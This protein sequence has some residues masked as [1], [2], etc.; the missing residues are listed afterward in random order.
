MDHAS[1]YDGMC[2]V[3]DSIQRAGSLD[4]KAIVA[5]LSKLDRKGYM[6]RY[7]FDQKTHTVKDGESFLAVPTA[8]IQKGKNILIWPSDMASGV[9][10]PQP[11]I[12]R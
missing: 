4:P 10:Q 3:L 12:G 5:A 7:V 6:G 8:Q 9:Y 1:G 2:N 11:W